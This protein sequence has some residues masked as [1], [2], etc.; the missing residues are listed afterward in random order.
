MTALH[1]F[2]GLPSDWDGLPCTAGAHKVDWMPVLAGLPGLREPALAALAEAL[3]SMV[4][5]DVL[6]GYAMGGRIALHMLLSEGGEKWRKAV[7]VSASPGLATGVERAARF[8][9]DQRWARRFFSESWETVA[10]AWDEQTVFT[11][12]GPNPLMRQ[13]AEFDR[14]H[15]ALALM[16][17]SVGRQSDLRGKLGVLNI[18]VLW[19][20]GERDA[21]YAALAREC[22]SLN[23]RF[24]CEILPD[25]GH[26]A[27]WTAPKAFCASVGAF[28]AE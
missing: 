9:A 3:N 12:D 16:R 19:I 8:N 17:G 22:A 7:V 13:E 2:L 14:K 23:R 28:L 26:R 24:R 5:G 4:P 10:S 1:G 18:P 27:P 6:L 25:A 20:A 15:L 21:K 11:T